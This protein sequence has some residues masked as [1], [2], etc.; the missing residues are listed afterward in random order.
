M[1]AKLVPGL[2]S[3]VISFTACT[4]NRLANEP[5]SLSAAANSGTALA[6]MAA[7]TTLPGYINDDFSKMDTLNWNAPSGRLENGK[8]AATMWLQNATVPYYR[9]F[10]QENG[11]VI[12]KANFPV[13]AIK[14]KTAKV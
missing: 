6:L 13:I 1:I 8:L 12:N 2:L 7:D 3:L 9:R 11:L 10:W 14:M 5:E 4:K